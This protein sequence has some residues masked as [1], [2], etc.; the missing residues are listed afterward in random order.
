MIIVNIGDFDR[1]PLV[2][3]FLE[4]IANSDENEWSAGNINKDRVTVVKSETLKWYGPEVALDAPVTNP[5]R[6]WISVI[7]PSM[8]TMGTGA[9]QI[10]IA[11]TVE[12]L[13]HIKDALAA[14]AKRYIEEKLEWAQRSRRDHELL[15]MLR[16]R[17]APQMA[18]RETKGPRNT[19]SGSLGF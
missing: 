5:E 3:Q 4:A 13:S 2:E 7:D 12:D 17:Y 18:Q 1:E 10:T 9:P 8:D 14:R 11:L 19:S 16:Q 15:D 6:L